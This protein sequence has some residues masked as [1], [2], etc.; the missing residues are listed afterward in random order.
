MTTK[1]RKIELSL[2]DTSRARI[3]VLFPTKASSAGYDPY[4]GHSI[5]PKLKQVKSKTDLRELSKQILQQRKAS[6]SEK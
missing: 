2:E 3:R 6:K 4:S 5:N 1:R